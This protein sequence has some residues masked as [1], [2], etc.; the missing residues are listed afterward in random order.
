MNGRREEVLMAKLNWEK[1][2]RRQSVPRQFGGRL[3]GKQA[4][5]RA[6]WL[7]KNASGMTVHDISRQTGIKVKDLARIVGS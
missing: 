6:R 4:E 7:Y 2:K 5:E 3:Y 1:A